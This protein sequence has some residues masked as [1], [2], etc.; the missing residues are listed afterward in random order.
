MCALDRY[1]TEL[2]AVWAAPFVCAICLRCYLV[3]LDGAE[4]LG[5]SCRGV[6]ERG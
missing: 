1:V 2:S 6:E 3:I 5:R 4:G